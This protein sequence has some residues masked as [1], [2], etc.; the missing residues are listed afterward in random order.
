MYV[1]IASSSIV[2]VTMNKYMYIV[3]IVNALTYLYETL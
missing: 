1:Y 2:A 3:I